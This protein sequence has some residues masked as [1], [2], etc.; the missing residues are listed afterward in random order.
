MVRYPGG[1]R[2]TSA[3]GLVSRIVAELRPSGPKDRT[4]TVRQRR[5][6][7]RKRKT[8]TVT[9]VTVAPAIAQPNPPPQQGRDIP[10]TVPRD[11]SGAAIDMAAYTAAIGL[12]GAAAYFSIRGMSVLFPW[13]AAGHRRHVGRNGR[14]EADRRG[15]ARPSMAQHPWIWR[16]ILM[17][18]VAGLALINAAGVFAQ[19][20]SAHVG[21]RGEA[22]SAIETKDAVIAARIEVAAHNVAD[23]DRRLGQ[24]DTA[25]EEAAKRGKTNAALSAIEGQRKSREALSGQRQ[26]EGVALADLKAERPAIGTRGTDRDRCGTDPIRCRCLR[27]DR[28]GGSNSVFGAPN[29]AHM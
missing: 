4:A 5:H 24:I 14:V 19:L 2:F 3:P 23:L 18:L 7:D 10:V 20:V 6:R 1:S 26:R 16:T 28:S 13:C 8:V 17:G 21:L 12:A 27:C 22:T 11:G 25:I 15:L 29:D 9:P